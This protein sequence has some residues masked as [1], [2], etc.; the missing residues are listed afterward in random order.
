MPKSFIYIHLLFT[1]PPF[2][3]IYAQLSNYMYKSLLGISFSLSP[4]PVGRALRF[5]TYYESVVRNDFY[6]KTGA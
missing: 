3:V 5:R 4:E 2:S 6:A 1:C